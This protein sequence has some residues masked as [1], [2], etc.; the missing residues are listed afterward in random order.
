MTLV[1]EEHLGIVEC[2]RALRQ[3]YATDVNEGRVAPVRKRKAAFD[4]DERELN[5]RS[6]VFRNRLGARDDAGDVRIFL[7][8]R[9]RLARLVIGRRLIAACPFAFFLL[10][11]L[12]AAA[13]FFKAFV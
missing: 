10:A 9:A 7:L 4:E 5:E 13:C 12:I 2:L 3:V 11:L 1:S 6:D 8:G